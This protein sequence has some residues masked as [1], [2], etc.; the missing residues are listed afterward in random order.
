MLWSRGGGGVVRS[1]VCVVR[2]I[3]SREQSRNILVGTRIHCR[4][5]P[6]SI[7][8]FRPARASTMSDDD[9]D[10]DIESDVSIRTGNTIEKCSGR[11]VCIVPPF[12]SVPRR[13]LCP[14]NVRILI[15]RTFRV[16]E[17]FVYT[18]SNSQL[19][20]RSILYN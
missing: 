18:L 12:R 17:P 2:A 19:S 8:H 6:L 4:V 15:I 11:P 3:E 10:I 14:S 1:R 5:C 20:N 13:R 16:S 7:V 9:R